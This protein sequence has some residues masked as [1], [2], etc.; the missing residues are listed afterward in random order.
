M[1]IPVESQTVADEN[2]PLQTI[3]NKEQVIEETKK[4]E[5]VE[6]EVSKKAEEEALIDSDEDLMQNEVVSLVDSCSNCQSPAETR[7]KIV[8]IHNISISNICVW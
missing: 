7:M 1:Q 3:A 4:F 5:E 2:T 6:V 8:G